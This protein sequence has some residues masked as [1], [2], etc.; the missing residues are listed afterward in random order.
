MAK[1]RFQVLHGCHCEGV[2][3]HVYEQ[4]EI[5][6]TDNDLSKHNTLNAVKFLKL[7]DDGIPAP[8]VPQDE[9][10]TMTLVELRQFADAEGIILGKAK[11]KVAV[12]DIIRQA[13]R[14]S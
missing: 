6:E 14:K 8:I 12:L 4:G 2:D 13:V 9:F 3:N 11:D 5:V 1:Y 10:D 7:S